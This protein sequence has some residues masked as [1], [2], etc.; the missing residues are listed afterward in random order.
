MASNDFERVDLQVQVATLYYKDK[1]SQQE[2]SDKLNMSRPTISRILQ[3]CL[4]DGIVTI[5]ILN[6]SSQQYELAMQVK[7]MFNLQFCSVVSS[8]VDR[9]QTLS[10]IGSSTVNYLDE[11]IDRDTRIG[12][13][14]GNTIEHIIPYLQPILNYKIEVFQM[15][16]DA[17][18]QLSTCSSFLTTS[19]SK[20]M[21]GE[22]YAMHVPL[23]VHSK[24]LRDL[25]LE[26]LP[27]KIHFQELNNLDIA[28]FGIGNIELILS[29]MNPRMY[30]IASKEKILRSLNV[31]G[32][33]CGHYLD[34]NG[35]ECES[36]LSD[37]TI[38]ISLEALKN[39]PVRIAV[40]CGKEK[41]D[42]AMAALRGGY[43]TSMILDE[44]LAALLLQ[45]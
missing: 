7:K 14:A 29:S 21:G 30:D 43:I 24:V 17:S 45:G 23:L 5:R 35:R 1:L 15:I 33:I 2:I 27:N 44:S 26:E 22:A 40:A 11:I 19:F 34:I 10:L 18:H 20:A 38:A 37:K 32:D 4:D 3:S 8:Q 9:E 6:T 13:S 36:E 31:V 41:R 25:L 12:I 42:I 16:G 28:L 39:V